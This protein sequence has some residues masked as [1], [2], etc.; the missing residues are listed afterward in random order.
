NLPKQPLG[1]SVWLRLRR[2]GVELRHPTGQPELLHIYENDRPA[3]KLNKLDLV[4]NSRLPAKGIKFF[5]EDS[6]HD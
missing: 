5:K 1:C 3:A 2:A 4:E 6:N